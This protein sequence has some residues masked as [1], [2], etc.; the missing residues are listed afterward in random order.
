MYGITSTRGAQ[1][2]FACPQSYEMTPRV[3]NRPSS[4]EKIDITPAHQGVDVGRRLPFQSPGQLPPQP[5]SDIN[6]QY[7]TAEISSDEQELK[8]STAPRRISA[9]TPRT[10][11]PTATG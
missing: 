9:T 10:V 3:F 4:S 2:T 6:P 5:R 1:V 11:D 7:G 8:T